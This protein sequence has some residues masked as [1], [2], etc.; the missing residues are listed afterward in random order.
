MIGV[1]LVDDHPSVVAGL[2]HLI[3]TADDLVLRGAAGSLGEARSL[4]S[5]EDVDVALIDVRLADGFGTTLVSEAALRGKP[6][7][8]ILSSFGH[9]QYVSAAL[10]AGARGFVLKTAPLSEVIDAIRRVGF[11]GTVFTAEQLKESQRPSVMLSERERNVIRHLV[12]SRS[13]DEIAHE[14]GLSR[15][16]IEA[17]LTR[18]FARFGALSR[19]ELAIRASNEGWLDV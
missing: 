2:A 10:R 17:T 16:T 19:T 6:A 1:A 14:L 7:T 8:L 12:L 5:R 11:G 13:N 3:G 9:P 4:L 18:L 15:K